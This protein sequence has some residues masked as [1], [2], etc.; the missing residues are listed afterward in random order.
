M[1]QTFNACFDAIYGPYAGKDFAI[2]LVDSAIMRP[3]SLTDSAA[4][5]STRNAPRRICVNHFVKVSEASWRD[6]RHRHNTGAMYHHI[7]MTGYGFGLTEKA[8][9]IRFTGDV[10]LNGDRSLPPLVIMSLTVS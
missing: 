7:Q 4:L 8:A 10:S 1:Y 9:D 6:F 5:A 3:P 2:T